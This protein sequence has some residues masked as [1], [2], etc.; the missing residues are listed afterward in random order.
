MEKYRV[1]FKPKGKQVFVP[2]GTILL[3]AAVD[4]G[5]KIRHTCGGQATCG[6]CRVLIEEGLD[7]LT[8][9]VRREIDL[10]GEER[11][12]KGYRLACQSKVKGPVK[13]QIPNWLHIPPKPNTTLE[14][15]LP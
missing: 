12:E 8:P 4:S 6:T 15:S 5:V 9:V 3:Q 13:A 11:L 7:N 2:A 14:A 1:Q 10:L